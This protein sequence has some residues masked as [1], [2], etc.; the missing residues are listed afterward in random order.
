MPILIYM[1]FG[2]RA[3]TGVVFI[4][5]PSVFYELLERWSHKRAVIHQTRQ[6][7][8]QNVPYLASKNIVLAFRDLVPK[9]FDVTAILM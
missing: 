7:I 9:Q 1:Q 6:F 8:V 4:S 5:E 2:H 3:H